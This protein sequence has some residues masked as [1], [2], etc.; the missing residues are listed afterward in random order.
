MHECKQQ[1]TRYM[2]KENES[3]IGCNKLGELRLHRLNR[4]LEEGP[5]LHVTTKFN[6]MIQPQHSLPAD[7]L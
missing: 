4:H 7:I 3:I 6:S 5:L 2:Y 1:P